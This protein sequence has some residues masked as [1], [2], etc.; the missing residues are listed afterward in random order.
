[1]SYRV[2]CLVVGGV[3]SGALC[4]GGVMTVNP[5]KRTRLSSL[6]S[7]DNGVRRTNTQIW[8]N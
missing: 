1:M 3:M 2:L 8:S 4:L 5:Q 7:L 6:M